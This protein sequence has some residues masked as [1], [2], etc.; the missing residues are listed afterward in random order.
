MGI[1]ANADE[2]ADVFD[3]W[4]RGPLESFLIEITAKIFRVKDPE[5]GAPLVDKVLDKA[6]Q[7]GTGKWTAQVALDLAVSDSDDRRGDRRARSLVDEGRARAASKVLGGATAASR[8]KADRKQFI[9]D[10]HD[11]LYASKICSYA[12]GMALIQAGS[13]S[14]SGTSTCARWRASGRPAASSARSSS[15]RS[16]AR[17]SRSRDLPNL[18]LDDEFTSAIAAAQPSWR[19]AVTFA[20]SNGIAVPAMSAS[21]AYFDAYRSAEL[22]QNLTQAQ[23]DY[24]GS[25]TYQ[26]NDKGPD[27]PFVHTD[28]A[29]REAGSL[30]RREWTEAV[31]LSPR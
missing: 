14:G 12:Q 4:N 15:T 27:A 6:G 22:P 24:F 2:L 9:S 5:T 23:R 1:G 16:C 28:W 13:R 17:T 10:V 25:H 18:L 7:K 31:T 30:G 29:K 8:R 3:Q 21:L 19:R 26:R 11:A 20:Q